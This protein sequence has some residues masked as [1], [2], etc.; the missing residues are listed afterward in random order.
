MAKSEDKNTLKVIVLADDLVIGD[1]NYKQG[2]KFV[3]DLKD[4]VSEGLLL[5]AVED[6]KTYDERMKMEAEAAKVNEEAAKK[7]AAADKKA[8]DGGSK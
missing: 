3:L 5:S 4:P 2:D 7:G 6:V 8:D 1:K